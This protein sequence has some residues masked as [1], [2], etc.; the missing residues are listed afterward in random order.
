MWNKGFLMKDECQEMKDECQELEVRLWPLR[1][2]ARGKYAVQAVRKPLIYVLIAF[3]LAMLTIAATHT[4]TAP[5]FGSMLSAIRV[6][7]NQVY[8]KMLRQTGP[9]TKKF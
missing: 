4:A 7:S 8:E 3:A 2:S 1:I 9:P 6:Y 5:V